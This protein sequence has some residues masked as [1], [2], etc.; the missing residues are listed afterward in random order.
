MAAE[1]ATPALD[2]LAQLSEMRSLFTIVIYNLSVKLGRHQ[3]GD[4]PD[5]DA[6]E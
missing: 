4:E 1:M 3:I 5:A 6:L 2:A